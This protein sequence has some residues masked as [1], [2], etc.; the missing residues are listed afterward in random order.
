[1]STVIK[2]IVRF[3]LFLLIQVY[4]LNH[5][6]P[7]H[8]FFIPYLYFL[9]LLWLPFSINR[10]FLLMLS[11]VYGFVLDAFTGS[12]GLYT[13]PCVLIGYVRP[14][15]LNLLIPQ[16]TSEQSFIEPSSNSMGTMPYAIYITILTLLHH[17]YLVLIE[18]LQVGN[19]LQFVGKVCG[20]TIIS[21]L[22]I[23]AT[24]LLFFRK[25]KYRNK[26]V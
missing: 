14:F 10:F 16:E 21:L 19:F 13:A 8:H 17:I 15:V 26:T 20:T 12:Y 22:L 1:M 4:V 24:E 11:F 18:W 9:F 7:L 5:V 6:P 3:I 2:N 25:A 23:F